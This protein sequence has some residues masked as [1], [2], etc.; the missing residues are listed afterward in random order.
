MKKIATSLNTGTARR[1][2]G[3]GGVESILRVV[4]L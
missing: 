4:R 2:G 1:R 3:E